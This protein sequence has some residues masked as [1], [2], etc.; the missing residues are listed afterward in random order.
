MASGDV[1]RL[2]KLLHRLNIVIGILMVISALGV[3]YVYIQTVHPTQDSNPGRAFKQ[4]VPNLEEELK[5]NIDKK[6]KGEKSTMHITLRV[7]CQGF[8]L[9]SYGKD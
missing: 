7:M 4:R 9:M 1:Y 8:I 3:H 5:A 6:N 2:L